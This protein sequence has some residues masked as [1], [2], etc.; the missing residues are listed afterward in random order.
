M[1]LGGPQI[2]CT[3]AARNFLKIFEICTFDV[4]NFCEKFPD[5]FEMAQFALKPLFF[6]FSAPKICTFDAQK[7]RFFIVR[8][9]PEAMVPPPNS[10]L[11]VMIYE[12]SFMNWS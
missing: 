5:F 3:F 12:C 4:S 9:P 8:V 1:N 7:T 10:S 6:K 11:I 2:F